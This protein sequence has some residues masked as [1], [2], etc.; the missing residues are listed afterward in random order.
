MENLN[1]IDREAEEEEARK[2][3]KVAPISAPPG[4]DLLDIDFDNFNAYSEADFAVILISAFV[5]KISEVSL[6]N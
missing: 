2:R 6:S 4:V 5:P 3:P 1:D